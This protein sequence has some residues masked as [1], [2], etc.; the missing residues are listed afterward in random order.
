MDNKT[1]FQIHVRCSIIIRISILQKVLDLPFGNSVFIFRDLD[2]KQEGN[3]R[4][5]RHRDPQ[6]GLPCPQPSSRQVVLPTKANHPPAIPPI[7]IPF[8][9]LKPTQKL[10]PSHPRE[11]THPLEALLHREPSPLSQLTRPMVTGQPT[12]H[13]EELILPKKLTHHK[14]ATRPVSRASHTGPCP[15][16]TRLSRHSTMDWAPAL[17]DQRIM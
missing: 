16:Q 11:P 5:R 6:V 17:V 9:Q 2:N 12:H 8:R 7:R 14:E 1:S 3:T 4:I 10:E 15:L 13:R